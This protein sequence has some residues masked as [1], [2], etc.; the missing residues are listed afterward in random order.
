MDKGNLVRNLTLG[1]RIRGLSHM[2]GRC[3]NF[4]HSTHEHKRAI[5]CARGP[6]VAITVGT[7]AI[8]ASFLFNAPMPRAVYTFNSGV[9]QFRYM[10]GAQNQAIWVSYLYNACIIVSRLDRETC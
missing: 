8:T 2:R 1:M 3:G 4:L 9:N 7:K 6:H 10:W 5:T